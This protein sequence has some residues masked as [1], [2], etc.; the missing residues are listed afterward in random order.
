MKTGFKKWEGLSKK[1]RNIASGA[2][3]V[4][5]GVLLAKPLFL[6]ILAS[7]FVSRHMYLSGELNEAADEVIIKERSPDFDSDP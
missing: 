4:I 5:T 2:S 6:L 3:F 1:T 7:L